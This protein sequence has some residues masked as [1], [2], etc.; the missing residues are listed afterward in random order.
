MIA[1]LF[2]MVKLWVFIFCCLIILKNVYSFNKVLLTQQG[3][4]NAT[5]KVLIT[6]GM[7]ISYVLTIL[8]I[9]F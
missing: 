4:Y 3:K 2:F 6:L 7:A 1:E 5:S 8:I 9:G